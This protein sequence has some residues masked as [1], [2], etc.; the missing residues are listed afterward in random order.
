M[1]YGILCNMVNYGDHC[2]NPW[3]SGQE[4]TFMA[5]E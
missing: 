2:N 5:Y 4:V 3:E 1:Y